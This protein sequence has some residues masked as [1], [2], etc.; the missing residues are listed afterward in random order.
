MI[1]IIC[2]WIEETLT[3]ANFSIY[4]SGAPKEANPITWANWANAGSANNG[5]WPRTSWQISGSGV[6]NGLLLCLIY[7]VLWNTLNANPAKK[8]RDANKPAT[9][10]NVN[11]VQSE[12][13]SY[14]F[15]EKLNHLIIDIN[16][17]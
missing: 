16:K 15:I 7:C 6:K 13:L 17:V 3:V 11:P 5:A 8:S 10:L 12:I 4:S 1:L 9:G 2:F 14:F